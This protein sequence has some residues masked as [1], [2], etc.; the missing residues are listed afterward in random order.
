MTETPII[1]MT[2]T[3]MI[4]INNI[5]QSLDSQ[6]ERCM[7]CE[8]I[9][10]IWFRFNG[11]EFHFTRISLE[12]A[13]DINNSNIKYIT[14]LHVKNCDIPRRGQGVKGWK[15]FWMDL[16]YCVDFRASFHETVR[17]RRLSYP[18]MLWS[19]HAARLDILIYWPLGNLNEI[20]NGF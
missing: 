14:K 6:D 7:F 18:Q 17:V 15:A 16:Y 1:I 8:D 13:E 11:N 9:G 20:S 2:I 10:E 19:L 5:H 4:M 3:I 12:N